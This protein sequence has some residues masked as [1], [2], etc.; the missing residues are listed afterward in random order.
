MYKEISE[1]RKSPEEVIGMFSEALKIMDRNTTK[2]MIDELQETIN[3]L[4]QDNDE[5]NLAI[6]EL[7]QGNDEKDMAISELQQ[8]NDEKDRKII[9]LEKR[10]KELE[11]KNDTDGF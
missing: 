4:K 5:K 2:Y 8:G 6:S 9:N 1:F 11:E 3:I 7:Q 10:I